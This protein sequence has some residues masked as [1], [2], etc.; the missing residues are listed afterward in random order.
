[1]AFNRLQSLRLV[2]DEL[3]DLL[4]LRVRLVAKCFGR[5]V[6]AVVRAFEELELH[7]TGGDVASH[8]VQR[9]FDMPHL[10]RNPGLL[11]NGLRCQAVRR[12]NYRRRDAFADAFSRAEY[13]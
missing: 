13:F 12:Y 1:M 4:L 10:V 7:I 8:N 6:C 9:S 3:F 2:A 11:S 5:D